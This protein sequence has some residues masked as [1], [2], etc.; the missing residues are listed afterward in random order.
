[1]DKPTRV[2]KESETLIDVILTS[3]RNKFLCA[4]AY[5]PDISDHHLVYAVMRA[6]CPKWTPRTTIRRNFKKFDSVQY[7]NDIASI[8]FH[9]A[10]TFEDIDDVYWAWEK[11]LIDVLNDHA[12]LV[13]KKSTKPRPF[14]VGTNSNENI[15]PPKTQTTWKIT[16]NK[17]IV[18]TA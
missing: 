10:N 5:N 8:P 4:G 13:E 14:A 16:D 1:M 3:K 7:N 2:T 12:P 11:L 18:L 6:A 15:T 17:E 9:V